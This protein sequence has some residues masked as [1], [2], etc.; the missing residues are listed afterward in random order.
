MIYTVKIYRLDKRC[1][2]GERFLNSYEFDRKDT[3]SMDRE[4]DELYLHHYP[5]SQFRIEY[6]EKFITV[7][8]LM[9][10]KDVVIDADTPWACRPDSEAY[11]SM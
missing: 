6:K 7:K 8:N 5:R 11:W 3:E 9:S 10:G 2:T 4:I 1:K